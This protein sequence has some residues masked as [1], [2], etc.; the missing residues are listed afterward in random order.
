VVDDTWQAWG[1]KLIAYRVWVG[2]LKER[3][4]FEDLHV[5]G[6]TVLK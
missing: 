1:K 6:R 2:R 5:G 3:D 4:H